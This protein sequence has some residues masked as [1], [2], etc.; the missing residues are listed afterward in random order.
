MPRSLLESFD[1]SLTIFNLTITPAS[2]SASFQLPLT[3]SAGSD[4]SSASGEGSFDASAIKATP[5]GNKMSWSDVIAGLQS[6]SLYV[7]IHTQ[8]NKPGEIR[9]Q[10]GMQ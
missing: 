9:G 8:N 10:V 1:S 4:P 6:G 2:G 5:D 7:N 3:I